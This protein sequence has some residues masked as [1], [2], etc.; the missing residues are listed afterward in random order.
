MTAFRFIEAEKANHTIRTM[1]R[2]LKV[3]R[4][5]FYDWRA[6]APEAACDVA[7]LVHIRSIHRESRGTYGSPRVTHELRRRGLRVN[8][9]RV[10]QVMRHEG[11]QGIPKRRFRGT[12]TRADPSSPVA[13]NLLQRDFSSSAP[14]KAWVADITYLPVTTGWAYLAVI[15]DLFSRKVVGWALDDSIDTNLCLRALA[16]AFA[17][18]GRSPGLIHHS[19]RGSQYT[20]QTYQAELKRQGAIPSMSRKGDCWDNAVAESFFGTLKQELPLEEPLLC[21]QAADKAISTYIQ[22]FYNLRRLHSTNG[23]RAPID[24][25]RDFHDTAADPAT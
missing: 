9:K 22:D 8:R 20:S 2:V 25:E 6:R 13:E 7:L 17:T 4:A 21:L 14:N 11:L 18:R 10:A 15:I 1:C 24:H 19:D 23:Y 3:S 5:G 12:T 16:R